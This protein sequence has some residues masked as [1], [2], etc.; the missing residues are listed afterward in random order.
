MQVIDG[1][2]YS[3]FPMAT[4]LL[5]T[6]IVWLANEIYPLTHRTDFYSYLANHAP[7]ASTANLEKFVASAMVALSAALMYLIARLQLQVAGSLALTLLFAFSTS[8]WSTASRALWQ[9]GPSVLFL[10]LGLYLTLVAVNH[11]RLIFCVG[12][13]LGYAY[14]VRPTNSLSVALFGLYFLVNYRRRF[15]FYVLGVVSILIPYIIQNWMTYHNLFPPYSYELFERLAS[16]AVFGEAL[17]GTLVSPGRGLFVFTP[18]FL[19]CMY[20]VYLAARERRLSLHGLDV[21]LIAVVISHW[22][23]ISSFED[24]IGGWSIGPRYFVDVIP[25]LM[26]LLVPFIGTWTVAGAPLRTAFLVA[27]LFGTLV[28]FHCSTSIDPFNWNCKPTVLGEAPERT[29]DWGDLQF[30]RGLC[31]QNPR[32]GGAPACWFEGGG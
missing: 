21:Y 18:I 26:Y 28:Q 10:S 7:N 5:V 20:G 25:F 3:Y 6:P 12:L 2:I 29:W 27:A 16:P 4:P 9:H 24:W 31:P 14:L 22:I 17:L 15:G 13:V 8:M 30:L 32:E 23:V 19:F 11:P 1:H